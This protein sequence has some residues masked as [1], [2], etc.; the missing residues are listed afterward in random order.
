MA[1]RDDYT[2]LSIRDAMA[3]LNQK[4]NLIGVV[5][6]FGVPK[7]S[8]G[9][10]NLIS[11]SSTMFEMQIFS[12]PLSPLL[13]TVAPAPLPSSLPQSLPRILISNRN[14][15]RNESNKDSGS[16]EISACLTIDTL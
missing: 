7:Q 10:G 3:S 12:Q 14:R 9:T 16:F 11:S 6:E 2:F 1:T 8:K 4:V 5:A 13:V 15:S